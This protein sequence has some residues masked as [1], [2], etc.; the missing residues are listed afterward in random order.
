VAKQISAMT[1]APEG[2]EVTIPCD[3]PDDDMVVICSGDFTDWEEVRFTG[4]NVFD[5][6]AKAREAQQQYEAKS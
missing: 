5:C 1:R 2:N 6:L 3:N 4:N